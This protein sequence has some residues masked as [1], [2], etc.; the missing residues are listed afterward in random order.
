MARLYTVTSYPQD[1]Q[2]LVTRIWTRFKSGR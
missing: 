1:V 2:R